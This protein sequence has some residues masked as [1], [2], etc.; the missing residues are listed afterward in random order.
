M[1]QSTPTLPPMATAVP[2]GPAPGNAAPVLPAPAPHPTPELDG[3]PSRI[4]VGAQDADLGAR[5]LGT[6]EAGTVQRT[7]VLPPAPK[8]PGVVEDH[9]GR[10]VAD[11]FRPLEQLDAPATVGW[12]KANNVRTN[13][14]LSGAER[15][16]AAATTWHQ[17][18]RNFTTEGMALERGGNS[19]FTRQAGL[20]PQPTY[21]VRAGGKQAEPRVLIDPNQL[22]PDGTVALQTTDPSPD[23]K[24]VAYTV[25]EAGSDQQTMRFRSVDTGAD[26][27]DEL[28]G[29]V[30]TSATWD[31]D[32]RGVIYSKPLPGDESAHFGIYRHVLGEDQSRDV[33]LHKRTDVENSFVEAFRLQA[34]DPVTFMT[35][36][37]GTDSATGVSFQRPGD[38]APTE[39]LPPQVAAM[40]PF[41]RD[42]DTLYAVTDLDAPRGRIVKVDMGDPAPER[43]ETLVPESDDAGNVLQYAHVAGGKLLVGRSMGGA[44]ALEV[45]SPDGTL[46]HEVPLPVAS[47]VELGQVRPGEPTF[48]LSVGGFLSPG[49]R[50]RYDVASNELTFVRK[51]D[52]PRDLTEIADVER[53]FAT[54]EDGTKVPMWVIKPKDL[55]KDGSAPTLLYG[56]GGFN[57][58]T[59]PEFSYQIAHWV[60]NGGVYAV[61]NLRGGGEFG[62]DWYDG[63]RLQ[64]KQNVF[65]DFAACARELVTEGYTTPAKLAIVGGSNGGLLTAV[66]SQQHPELFGA[67]LSHVPVTDMLRFHLDGNGAGWMSDYGD[68]GDKRDFEASI[69]YSPLHNVQPATAV[70]YPP[71]LVLTGDHDDRV[72]PWHAFKWAA[73]RQDLGHEATTYLRVDER[74]GHGAGKPTAKVIAQEADV[75]AFLVRA[76]GLG[77]DQVTASSSSAPAK[78]APRAIAATPAG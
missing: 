70:A 14:F 55:P 21:Y 58:S 5:S 34:D 20:A 54:S 59:E 30:F 18:M 41:H 62:K 2:H 42:G 50:Y 68:P 78:P 45:R 66:T 26:L 57:V 16:R 69:K 65:D 74:S 13:E 72:A 38:A 43:W 52:I 71:T 49:T 12:W 48:E 28:T 4:G 37:S 63:G 67:V 10:K 77:D 33:L 39:I 46:Q 47:K 11:P 75:Y 3:A 31:P 25:S 40:K 27:H 24:L 44:T 73:T 35:V 60:E 1:I 23:G 76:L 15:A 7:S 61:A 6:P 53:S 8:D 17:E 19:F 22:S 32:A 29:L 36:Y 9:H 51:S 56:Y 64:N